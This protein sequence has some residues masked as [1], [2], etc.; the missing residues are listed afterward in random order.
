MR[1][2]W[3]RRDLRLSDN[4][5][6]ADAPET[7]AGVFVF[8]DE[9]LEHAGAPRVSFML[10]ALASLREGYRDRGSE[11]FVRR[12]DPAAVLADLAETRDVEM[13]SWNRDY[14]GLA[15]GRDERASAALKDAGV[16]PQKFHDA[17][18]HEPGSITTNAGDPYSVYTYFWKKWR[19]REKGDPRP[20]PELAAADDDEPLPTLGEL[21]F[22][23]PPGTVPPAGTD[24]A[25]SLLESFLEEEVLAYEERRD[26]PAEK[27]TSRLSPHMKFGTIGIRE[28]DERVRETLADTDGEA[29]ESVEEFRSQLAWREFYTHV[30]NFNPGVV[31]ENYKSYENDIEWEDDEELLKAWKRGETGYPIVDAGMRQLREES[32]MH[33]RVRMIVA[34]FLTKDLLIDWRHGYDHFRE[35][36]VDHDTAND[37]GGWQWAASTGTDAQPYFRIFNP[38]T[39][40]ERYDPEAEYITE[41]V[42]ELRGVDPEIIHSWHECSLTQ[43]R[44]VAPEYPDPVV[45]HSE[46]REEALA[47][48]EQARGE[49]DSEA[50]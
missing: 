30:L 47:M 28:V 1:L 11:L 23:D 29:H 37:N 25:R 18:C 45:D 21:G 4:V 7:P 27:P 13:V 10:D 49:A 2:H 48:F 14:S 46:R 12:G 15:R 43:R 50:D 42:P 32:Y 6:L 17:I 33:N 44:N 9:V 24:E 31:T 8:D 3:H 35:L 36:L 5:G 41:Y 20:V 34:S 22:D 19:D 38:M 39:Q 40:G 26:Y 16:T